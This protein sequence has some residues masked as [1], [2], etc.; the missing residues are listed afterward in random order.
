MKTLLVIIPAIVVALSKG[1]NGNMA[2]TF[3]GSNAGIFTQL[4]TEESSCQG[5]QAVPTFPSAPFSHQNGW[6]A[7]VYTINGEPGDVILCG[8]KDT[9]ES[10]E[11]KMIEI[12]TSSWK[13]GSCFLPVP[14][15]HHSMVSTMDG[16]VVI[17][18]GYSE[19][20]GWLPEV[21][22]LTE[23][24][25]EECN[26][27]Q[28]NHCCTWEK[29]GTNP[30]NAVY[31]HCSVQYD[32]DH[33]AIIG[34]NTWSGSDGQYDVPDIQILNMKTGEWKRGADMPMARQ[35]AGCIKTEVNGRS[36][37]LV[38]GGFCHGNPNFDECDLLRLETTVF[39][40][41]E[42][43]SWEDLAAPLLE[44]RDGLKIANIGGKILA[45]GGEFRGFPVK[46]VEEWTN[47]GWA[48]AHFDI[49]DTKDFASTVIPSGYYNC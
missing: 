48:P 40:D 15:T 41:W 32:E 4:I 17:S 12:G 5:S 46:G 33:L 7:G 49:G 27:L 44:P 30:G 2:V 25:T 19:Q 38:A 29:I 35:R 21:Y 47:G 31:A 1:G 10:N 39:Y 36:G 22:K 20:I 23:M 24:R 43:D 13:E 34:G 18:G 45:F 14:V 42:N 26:N 9:T 3:G 6:A 11:C 8:G 16:T 28:T 37:I